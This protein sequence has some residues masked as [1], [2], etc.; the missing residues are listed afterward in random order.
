MFTGQNSLT[1]DK[2]DMA[3]SRAHVYVHGRVQGVSFRVNTRR[4]A[5]LF[6]VKGWVKNCD[7]GSVE[8]VFEGE[9]AAVD[10]IVKWCKQGPTGA[11]VQRFDVCWEDYAGEFDSFS[12]VY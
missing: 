11:L 10:N 1:I 5:Q 7:D 6:G 3:T 12:I 2:I 8:A 4:N 9:K